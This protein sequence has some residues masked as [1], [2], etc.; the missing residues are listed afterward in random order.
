MTT[1]PKIRSRWRRGGGVRS[2]AAAVGGTTIGAAA[3]FATLTVVAAFYDEVT[4]G[5]LSAVTAIFQL[6]SVSLRLGTDVAATYFIGREPHDRRLPQARRVL[7]ITVAPVALITTA[8]SAL[9]IRHADLLASWLAKPAEQD[10]YSQMVT[11]VALA[12]PL[13]AVGEVLMSATRGF[14]S[15][16]ATVIGVNVGRQCGQLVLVVAAVIFASDETDLLAAAWSAPFLVTLLVPAGWLAAKGA[17]RAAPSRPPQPARDIWAYAAPQA[18]GA[19][20]QGGL[21]KADIMML[22]TMVGAEEAAHYSL[23]NRFVHLFVLVRYALGSAHAAAIAQS[24]RANDMIAVHFR[25]SQIAAWSLVL[26]GPGLVLLVCFPTTVLGFVGEEYVAGGGPLQILALGLLGSLFL[27][28]SL[29]L[30]SLSGAG[31]RALAYNAGSLL[32]NVVA[33]AVLISAY[34]AHGAAWAWAVAMIVPRA[35]AHRYIR[36]RFDIRIFTEP[37]VF[38]TVTTAVIA[39]VAVAGR[40]LVGDEPIGLLVT[41]PISALV[42][43]GMV[44][45]WRRRLAVLREPTSH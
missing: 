27:G 28:H 4:F 15:M 3:N 2:S 17:L 6:T 22:N 43:A 38:A 25:H 32:M 16:L 30:V 44:S 45:S 7:A 21:E 42:W 36:Q 39:T 33:N 18:A 23:A 34:G 8:L 12:L 35:A 1:T 41:A 24:L 19:A 37:V 20:V 14:E 5:T 13:S 9:V 10:E 26:C 29:A 31:A 11:I 40:S